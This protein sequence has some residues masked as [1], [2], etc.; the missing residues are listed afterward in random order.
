MLR[1]ALTSSCSTTGRLRTL[2]ARI[3]WTHFCTVNEDGTVVSWLTGVISCDTCVLRPAPRSG[4]SFRKSRSVMIPASPAS[5]VT[6]SE[7]I[8][9]LSMFTA[10]R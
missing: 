9:Y 3:V 5:S 8:R 2:T 1:T 7:F 4:L 10:A 6:T